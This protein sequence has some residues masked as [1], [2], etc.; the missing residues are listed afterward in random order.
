MWSRNMM[1]RAW[2]NERLRSQSQAQMHVIQ[3]NVAA[4][5]KDSDDEQ[6]DSEERVDKKRLL[7]AISSSDAQLMTLMTD[8]LADTATD[9]ALYLQLVA[10]LRDDILQGEFI[11]HHADVNETLQGKLSLKIDLLKNTLQ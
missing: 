5:Q 11:S 1:Q 4:Q 7:T 8:Y 9:H 10:L 6:S 3:K 2:H